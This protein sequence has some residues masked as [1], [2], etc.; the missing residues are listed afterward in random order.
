MRPFAE[1]S[2]L[3]VFDHVLDHGYNS[4][5]FSSLMLCG[6]KAHLASISYPCIESGDRQGPPDQRNPTASHIGFADM[7]DVEDY[8]DRV[9]H[10]AQIRN[11]RHLADS[12]H[13]FTTATGTPIDPANLRRAAAPS[14]RLPNVVKWVRE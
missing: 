3:E 4:P 11:G 12:G 14:V 9:L 7:I 1:G 8:G 2:E 13:V 10:M 5:P 6:G